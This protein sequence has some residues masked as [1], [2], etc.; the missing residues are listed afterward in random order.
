MELL[1]Q[2]G[3]SPKLLHPPGPGVPQAVEAAGIEVPDAAMHP[4]E[5]VVGTGHQAGSVTAFALWS[6]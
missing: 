3:I 2:I 4:L 6:C 1:S 5:E